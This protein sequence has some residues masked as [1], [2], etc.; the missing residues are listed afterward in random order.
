MRARRV[1]LAIAVAA[2]ASC[3]RRG[4]PP[5]PAL[6]GAPPPAPTPSYELRL[7]HETF[8][9]Y[10]ATCHGD[11]GA[12]DGFNAYNLDPHP[13]DLADPAFQEKSDAEIAD[14]IRRGGS[15]VGLSSL[16]PP[17]GHTLTERQIGELVLYVRG[18]KRKP[19]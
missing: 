7:G 3:A 18:L 1:A 12:G 19:A 10:C 8:A 15:G 5:E 9:H 11:A 16:M 17:W 13:R 6:V 2:L 4:A 14:S